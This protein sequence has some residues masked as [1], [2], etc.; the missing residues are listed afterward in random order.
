MSNAVLGTQTALISDLLSGP[1]NGI[2][3]PLAVLQR[4]TAPLDEASTEGFGTVKRTD[5][6]SLFSRTLDVLREK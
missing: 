5:F 6:I 4:A 3:A 1:Q 2:S